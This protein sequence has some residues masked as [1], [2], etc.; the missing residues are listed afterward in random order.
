MIACVA[1]NDWVSVS[2]FCLHDV[3]VRIRIVVYCSFPNV[4]NSSAIFSRCIN[5]ANFTV[6]PQPVKFK[7]AKYSLYPYTP[8]VLRPDLAYQEV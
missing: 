7:L 5:F 8:Y 3:H 6:L 2:K 4:H 1:S